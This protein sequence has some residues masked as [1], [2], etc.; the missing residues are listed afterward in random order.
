ML[1]QPQFTQTTS[2]TYE[3]LGH[4]VQQIIADPQMQ[5]VQVVTVIRRDDESL[6]DW[7]RLLRDLSGTHGICIEELAEGEVRI[8]WR[9]FCEA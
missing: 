6:T 3:Q 4:R 8:G 7:N 1:A 2:R 9:G 5:K